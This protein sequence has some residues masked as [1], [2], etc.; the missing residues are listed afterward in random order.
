MLN[1]VN[2]HNFFIE[3]INVLFLYDVDYDVKLLG[4]TI[5]RTSNFSSINCFDTH[6]NGQSKNYQTRLYLLDKQTPQQ[7]VEKT[8]DNR[9]E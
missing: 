4:Q 8:T 2:T 9:L 5:V 6:V 1:E 7:T 3:S